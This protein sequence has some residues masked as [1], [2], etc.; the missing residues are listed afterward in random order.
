MFETVRMPVTVLLVV[1]DRVEFTTPD[2]DHKDPMTEPLARVLPLVEHLGLNVRT[3]P[4]T[5]LVALIDGAGDLV[6]LERP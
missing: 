5:R 3:L 1:G 2:R 6:G 4:G